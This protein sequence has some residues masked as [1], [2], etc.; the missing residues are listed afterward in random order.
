MT[1]KEISD[2]LLE[3]KWISNLDSIEF[4]ASGEYNENFTVIADGHRYVFRINHGSQLGIEDQIKYEYSAL[5]AVAA[6]ERTPK[7][8]SYSSAMS[9]RPGVLLEEFIA[10]T[11]LNYATNSSGVAETF[12]RIHNLEIDG[13]IPLPLI[14]QERMIEAIVEES[15]S[16]RARYTDHPKRTERIKIEKYQNEIQRRTDEWSREFAQENSCIVNTEV[17]SGNF[18]V[19][20]GIPILLDWEKA[21][22]S[23]RY[24]DLGHYVVPTT[25]LWKSDFLFTRETRTEFLRAYLEYVNLPMSLDE[26][27]YLTS[28][29]ERVILL[30][31]LS[32][33]YMAYYEY[34]STNRSLQN[35]TTFKR[36][37]AY[38]DEIDSFLDR[39]EPE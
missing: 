15:E 22:I 32:W 18:I 35:K 26:L 13:T 28:I 9:R 14:N 20:E 5:K 21:V 25:T 8:H 37:S 11:P 3:S 33:C 29:V 17:N 24:Q 30:R 10:G 27:S 38:L 23:Y 36:I 31:A 4:L 34:T 16:M 19:R 12:S 6:S 2:F 7:P 39:S 1:Q